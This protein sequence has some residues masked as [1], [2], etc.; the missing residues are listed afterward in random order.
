MLAI[1]V[2]HFSD[3][4]LLLFFTFCSEIVAF[5]FYWHLIKK[6]IK[7]IVFFSI[8]FQS[9]YLL[10]KKLKIIV[11]TTLSSFCLLII[12]PTLVKASQCSRRGFQQTC[13]IEDSA[14]KLYGLFCNFMRLARAIL[15]NNMTR[16]RSRDS[17]GAVRSGLMH[18]FVVLVAFFSA[19][20]PVSACEGISPQRCL[21]WG[22]GL[23]ADAV[24]PVRYLFIQAVNSK[25][26]N[27]TLSPGN[28]PIAHHVKKLF[29]YYLKLQP[30]CLYTVFPLMWNLSP[31]ANNK[32]NKNIHCKVR[33]NT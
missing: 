30:L 23:R 17:T 15:L 5:F 21:V 33:N 10:K 14:S 4:F 25:G 11:L 1:F 12:F 9:Y 18:R 32:T 19:D 16:Q 26:E 8:N 20:L 2:L 31:W 7:H 29:I 28:P 13:R 27:L 6:K 22:P 24:L 3:I